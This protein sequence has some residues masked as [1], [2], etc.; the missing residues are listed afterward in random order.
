MLA[1]AV[2][3]SLLFHWLLFHWL[4]IHWLLIHWLL[5]HWLLI[6]WLLIHWLL[7]HWL[8]GCLPLSPPPCPLHY[9]RHHRKTPL[10]SPRN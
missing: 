7:I 1:A 3:G 6:H 8:L 4:L 10:Q 2:S 5:I 9:P